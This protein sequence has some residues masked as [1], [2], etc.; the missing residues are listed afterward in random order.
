[1]DE[2]EHLTPR[3]EE[4]AF[5]LWKRP[6]FIHPDPLDD[7]ALYL[8]GRYYGKG[9]VYKFRKGSGAMWLTIFDNVTNINAYA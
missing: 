8:T 2:A 9:A 1:M 3:E 4:S 7:T 5:R 6:Q